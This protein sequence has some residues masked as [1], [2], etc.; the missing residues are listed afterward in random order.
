MV[1]GSH[2]YLCAL[3]LSPG[4]LLNWQRVTWVSIVELGVMAKGPFSYVL[5]PGAWCSFLIS[6]LHEERLPR[7]TQP[8]LA[9][10][11]RTLALP[12]LS[13]SRTHYSQRQLF[14]GGEDPPFSWA[15]GERCCS[16][17]VM[18]T[19]WNTPVQVLL[20]L[21]TMEISTKGRAVQQQWGWVSP[22]GRASDSGKTTE[23]PVFVLG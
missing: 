10:R 5:W 12:P 23:N 6:S 11:R 7:V 8:S 18:L 13:G 22:A 16:P 19:L 1:W 20:V 2:A 17:L 3:S 9:N 14:A 4:P 21:N 15:W